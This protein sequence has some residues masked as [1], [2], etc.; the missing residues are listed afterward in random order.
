MKNKNKKQVLLQKFKRFLSKKKWYDKPAIKSTRKLRTSF[1]WQQENK[2]RISFKMPA[3]QK[4]KK[5]KI[6]ATDAYLLRKK[7]RRFFARKYFKKNI[8]TLRRLHGYFF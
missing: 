4:I 7:R 2:K 3:E 8:R 5:I 1:K 6:N